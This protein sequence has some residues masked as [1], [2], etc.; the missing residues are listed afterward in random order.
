MQMQPY[1]LL[2]FRN[3]IELEFLLS[4]PLDRLQNGPRCKGF[5]APRRNG[6]TLTAPGRSE[7][8]LP[9]K[10]ERRIMKPM[11]PAF[12][13][14]A[15][16]GAIRLEARAQRKGLDAETFRGFQLAEELFLL[17]SF[18]IEPNAHRF[19][20]SLRNVQREG[21]DSESV[22]LPNWRN[23]WKLRSG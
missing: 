16:I 5:A 3:R 18:F 7:E 1:R 22:R 8:T 17:T 12:K 14:L 13:H 9:Y 11:T 2:R 15:H 4:L 20:E 6:A 23:E 21:R 10:R 19:D